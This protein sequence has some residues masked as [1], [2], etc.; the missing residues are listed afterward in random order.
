M[1]GKL[2]LKPNQRLEAEQLSRFTDGV[3]HGR[4]R[5]ALARH[6]LPRQL[7]A[8]FLSGVALATATA[9]WL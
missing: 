7:A 4:R 5:M 1:I 6:L 3:D 2:G 8:S 9:F